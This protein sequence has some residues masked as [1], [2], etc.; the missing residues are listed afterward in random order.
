MTAKFVTDNIDRLQ[1]IQL[2]APRGWLITFKSLNTGLHH[3]MYVNGRLTGFTDSTDQRSFHLDPE[4]FGQRV[5]IVAVDAESRSVDMSDRLSAEDA[6]PSWVYQAEVVRP[7]DLTPG[8]HLELLGDRT[9]GQICSDPLILRKLSPD[10]LGRW[11]FGYQDFALG[12]LGYDGDGA[13]GAGKGSFGAGRFGFGAE[14]VRISHPVNEQ[15]THQMML[16]VNSLLS[17][18]ADGQIDYFQCDPPPAAPS[19]L[20]AIAYDPQTKTLT[21]QIQ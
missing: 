5:A 10:W 20:Q 13:P 18:E 6:Q 21:L 8:T 7:T 3:Q 1:A 15:G 16:R 19:S 17:E 9:T 2:E 11:G 4:S 12:Q 14:T